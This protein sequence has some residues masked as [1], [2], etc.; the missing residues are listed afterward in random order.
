[1]SISSQFILLFWRKKT[2]L[3]WLK[4]KT[5]KNWVSLLHYF[6]TIR[7]ANY[8]FAIYLNF[9]IFIFDNSFKITKI[10]ILLKS[11]VKL[12][13]NITV[14]AQATH[15]PLRSIGLWFTWFY[16]FYRTY[17]TPC[18]FFPLPL[19]IVLYWFFDSNYKQSLKSFRD[20][21]KACFFILKMLFE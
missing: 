5:L 6:K 13:L 10:T 18:R 8:F 1:M 20:L 15:V 3:Y 16:L 19:V 4:G 21:W 2:L 14:I 9:G 11:T 12:C 7:K 17:S